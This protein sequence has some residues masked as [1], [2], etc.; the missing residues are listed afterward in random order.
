MRERERER[1]RERERLIMWRTNIKLN[2]RS[3]DFDVFLAVKSTS[4]FAIS[5][6]TSEVRLDF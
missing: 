6:L 4:F 3:K 1:M 2:F 5:T